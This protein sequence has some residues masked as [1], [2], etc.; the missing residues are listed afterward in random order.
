MPRQEGDLREFTFA[1][2]GLQP[3]HIDPERNYRFGL[4]GSGLGAVLPVKTSTGDPAS[5]QEGQLY[6]NTGDNTLQL[7]ADGAWHTVAS[8]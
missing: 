4:N 3:R 1:N 8:W 7:Y 2:R 5:P 6:V